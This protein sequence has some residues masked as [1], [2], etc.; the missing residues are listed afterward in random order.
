VDSFGSGP[1]VLRQAFC[2]EGQKYWVKKNQ[3]NNK[4]TLQFSHNMI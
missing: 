4:C 1:L 3:K 2:G